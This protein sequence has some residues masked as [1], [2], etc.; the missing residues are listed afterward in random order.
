[1]EAT[2]KVVR[3][4]PTCSVLLLSIVATNLVAIAVQTAVVVV[5][6][7]VVTVVVAV[8]TEIVVAS[9]IVAATEN[10]VIEAATEV[11]A[12][13]TTRW[14]VRHPP[15]ATKQSHAARPTH[16]MSAT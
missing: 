3:M 4:A 16:A 15:A 9:E 7:V 13:A 14:V 2:V 8:A 6:T 5:E 11:D 10:V 12:V 1:V